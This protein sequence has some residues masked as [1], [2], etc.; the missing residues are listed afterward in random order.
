MRI[1]L[2]E[3]ICGGGYA[4]QPLSPSLLS[5]GFGMLRGLAEDFK[6]AGFEVSALLDSRIMCTCPPFEADHVIEVNSRTIADV[7]LSLAAESADMV[8]AVAPEAGSVLQS[9]VERVED[10]GAISLNCKPETI[11]QAADKAKLD[12]C[13]RHLGLEYP[14]TL[15]LKT[16]EVEKVVSEVKGKLG[17]P[18]VVKPLASA[19]CAGLSIVKDEAD[20]AAGVKKIEV[21]NDDGQFIAQKLVVGVPVSV[22]LIGNGKKAKPVS[23]NLQ[24]VTLAPPQAESSYNGG[25]VPLDHPLR[26]KA[27]AAAKMLVESFDGLRGYIGV[28]FVLANDKAYVL[29]INPRLTTSFVGLRKVANFNLAQAIV[30]AILKGELPQAQA[31]NGYACFSKAAMPHCSGSEWARACGLGSVV[32]PPFPLANAKKSIALLQSIAQT[33]QGAQRRLGEAKRELAQICT[34][35]R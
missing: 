1:L 13:V 23:L 8:Y 19:G 30:D 6:V 22:S 9:I 24:N 7:T 27:F 3:H 5:E 21:E 35:G 15:K 33:R 31:T 20:I 29:E 32:S 34:G 28:D 12:S 16:V 26:E 17:F 14:R 18:A 10:A 11:R 2:Y 4:G 25:Q